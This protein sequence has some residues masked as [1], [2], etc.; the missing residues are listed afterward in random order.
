MLF[1]YD[2]AKG[3]DL[4]TKYQSVYGLGVLLSDGVLV[5]DGVLLGDTTMLSSGVL[6]G[7]NIMIS[8]GITMSEAQARM[9]PGMLRP[10]GF[11]ASRS[12]ADSYA[13]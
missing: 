9:I 5:S 3:S 12:W 4:I 13:R 2:W 8:S 10:G 6:L 11:P 1:Q 7:D